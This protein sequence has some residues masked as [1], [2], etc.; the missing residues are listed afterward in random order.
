[1]GATMTANRLQDIK[2]PTDLSDIFKLLTE[3]C[4]LV[5][6]FKRQGA[7]EPLPTAIVKAACLRVVP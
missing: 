6:E 4:G 5:Q 7:Q 3:I 1:M 2:R